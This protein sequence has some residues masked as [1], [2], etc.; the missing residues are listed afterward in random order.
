MTVKAAFVF[1]QTLGHVTYYRNLRG[2]TE[3]QSSLAPTW[4]PIGF[5]DGLPER[6]LPLIGQNWS[7]QASWKARRAVTNLMRAGSPDVLFFHTQV[8]SLFS[9]DIMRRVPT[10]ISL[11]ATPINFDEVGA[12]YN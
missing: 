2:I 12:H 8:T 6:A 5:S 1:E 3:R 9:T 11:D 7:V 4:V 10:V